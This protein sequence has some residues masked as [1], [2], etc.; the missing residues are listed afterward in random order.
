MNRH[1]AALA[2]AVETFPASNMGKV[3]VLYGVC[4]DYGVQQGVTD[5]RQYC[6]DSETDPKYGVCNLYSTGG[7]EFP[8]VQQRGCM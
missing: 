6:L 2:Y 1:H 4:T 3:C 7:K 8:R 5:S